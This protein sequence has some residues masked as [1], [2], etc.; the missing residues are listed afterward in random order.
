MAK[1]VEEDKYRIV[2]KKIPKPITTN[3][4][5]SEEYPFAR[6]RYEGSDVIP[7]AEFELTSEEVI[8]VLSMLTRNRGGK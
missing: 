3:E 4:R 2:I 6:I 7:V 1:K 8:E 5:M